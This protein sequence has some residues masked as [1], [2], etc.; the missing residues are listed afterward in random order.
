ML[1]PHPCLGLCLLPHTHT[2]GPA[3][4][5]A[6]GHDSMTVTLTGRSGIYL[7]GSSVRVQEAHK[8]AAPWL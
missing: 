1:L 2:Q 6:A 4:G 7:R 5:A 3:R 8:G